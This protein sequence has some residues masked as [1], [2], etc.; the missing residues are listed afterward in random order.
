MLLLEIDAL[1]EE[2]AVLVSVDVPVTDREPVCVNELDEVS[3]DVAVFV[4][5]TVEVRE[6]LPVLV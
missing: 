2:V 1:T 5:E 4:A 3:E 6:L